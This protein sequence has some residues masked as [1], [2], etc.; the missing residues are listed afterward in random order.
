MVFERLAIW[1]FGPETLGFRTGLVLHEITPANSQLTAVSI[2]GL[3][4]QRS[5]C[6]AMSMSTATAAGGGS[7]MQQLLH[8]SHVQLGRVLQNPCNSRQL[9]RQRQDRVLPAATRHCCMQQPA[10]AAR[11]FSGNRLRPGSGG[12][13]HRLRTSVRDYPFASV[14]LS[15]LLASPP[16]PPPGGGLPSPSSEDQDKEDSRRFRRTVRLI[17]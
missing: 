7:A 17:L 15:P 5:C 1:S 2:S 13:P 4:T 9:A 10:P 6:T 8:C 3:R 16:E 14:D 11:G 12:R